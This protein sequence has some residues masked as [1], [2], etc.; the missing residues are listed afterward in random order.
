MKK[1]EE[2]LHDLWDTLKWISIH[3][4]EILEGAKMRKGRK[5]I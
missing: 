3:I 4:M 1:S 5:F 2:N